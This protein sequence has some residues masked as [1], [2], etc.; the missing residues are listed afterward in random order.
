MASLKHNHFRAKGFVFDL[1]G[2]LIDTTPLVTR[3]WRQFAIE[4]GI[5]GDKILATSH[6]VRT[7]E[8]MARW[9]PHKATED[10]VRDF[11]KRLAEDSEG[12]S[13]LPGVASLIDKIPLGHWGVCTAGTEYMAR[14]RLE[15]CDIPAPKVLICGDMV[16]Q[17]K[18]H[19]EPYLKAIE[20]LNLE[21]HNVIVFEDAP[22]GVQSAKAA[23]AHVI[24]C[25]TTHT[26]DQ[27]KEAGAD[28]IVDLLTDV[29]FINLPDGSFEVQATTTS[30]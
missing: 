27:L 24:A 6:G 30:I 7:I 28:C 14:K 15:Q 13:V 25:K 20:E 16:S 8:T 10:H 21:P 22:A 11:E 9:T 12:V 3:F 1:D 18:P 29:D 5:D 4:N 2:T 23:G 26:A 17:G 19:P